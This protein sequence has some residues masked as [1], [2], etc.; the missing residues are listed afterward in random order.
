MLNLDFI[1]TKDHQPGISQAESEPSAPTTAQLDSSVPH[2]STL[3]RRFWRFGI[4]IAVS[5]LIVL[6]GVQI[7]KHREG[8][9]RLT[10]GHDL[11]PSYTAGALVRS[12]HSLLMY[13]R[14]AI[15]RLEAGTIAQS[16]LTVEHQY[17]AW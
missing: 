1:Q 17:G 14:A 8:D 5:I 3:T 6:T 15:E 7:R 16:N 4:A 2:G 10:F 13:D 9:T 12:G 11:L